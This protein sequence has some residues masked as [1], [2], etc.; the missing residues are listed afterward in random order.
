M[1]P[2]ATA[3]TTAPT[4]AATAVREVPLQGVRCRKLP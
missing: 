4:A 2:A 3:L 1:L